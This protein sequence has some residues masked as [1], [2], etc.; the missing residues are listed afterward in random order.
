MNKPAP[1]NIA[2]GAAVHRN[3]NN[4]SIIEGLLCES[5]FVSPKYFYDSIGSR[6]FELITMV[7][8]YYPTRTEQTLMDLHRASIAKAVGPVDTLIDLGAGNCHK[9]RELFSSIQPKQY[10]A[11]D[12]SEDFLESSLVQMREVFP[13][14]QMYALGADLTQPIKLAPAMQSHR[15]VCFYPGSSIG[16]F[17]PNHAIQLLQNFRNL[18]DHNIQ[19]PGSNLANASNG[20]LLIG[21][22]LVKD[23]KILHAAYNDE[24]GITAAFNRNVLSHLNSLISSDFNLADWGHD[25]FF[26]Q[27]LSR[28]EMHVYARR[29]LVVTWPGGER[30]FKSGE[31]IHTENSYKYQIDI[32]KEMLL[33]AG[34]S[35]IQFWTDPNQWFAVF[36]AHA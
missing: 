5:A 34:Y 33:E 13:G 17:D 23:D 19:D 9:A 2:Q 12:I 11:I 14:I 24:L 21:V 25:A 30:H 16:N 15:K 32:F 7:P 31:S 18:A 35:D 8:E 1:M 26:N 20:G 4:Q 22:D 10:L 27:A 6:L 28:I 29:D 3:V 36:L